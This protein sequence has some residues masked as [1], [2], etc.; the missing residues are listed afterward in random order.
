M[1]PESPAQPASP[2]TATQVKTEAIRLGFSAC[3]V[4]SLEPLPQ[5]Q[6]VDQWL[7]SGKAGNMRYLHRQAKKR[8]NPQVAD[9]SAK[10][11]IVVLDSYYYESAKD[12]NRPKVARYARGTDYHTVTLRRLELLAGFLRHEGAQAG[13]ALQD[14]GP[15]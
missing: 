10:R 7:A 15:R 3:A 2:L 1:T 13:R 14:S 9:K 8:K 12:T 11:A 6:D 4:N 5:N